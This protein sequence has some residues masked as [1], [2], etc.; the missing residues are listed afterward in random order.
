MEA[1]IKK[2]AACLIIKSLTKMILEQLRTTHWVMQSAVGDK[3]IFVR[4]VHLFTGNYTRTGYLESHSCLNVSF[5][6]QSCA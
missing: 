2:N 1:L 5:H 6:I 4:S 3:L